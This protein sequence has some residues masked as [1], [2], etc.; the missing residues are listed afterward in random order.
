MPNGSYPSPQI[1]D[2]DNWYWCTVVDG[3]TLTLDKPY[4]GDTSGG[5]VYPPADLADPDRA[6]LAAVYARDHGLGNELRGRGPE[7]LQRR[8]IGS[9]PDLHEQGCGLAVELWAQSGR[10]TDWFTE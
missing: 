9:I 8:G 6:G 4:T 5:N 10:P 2:T 3:N 1:L 7:G